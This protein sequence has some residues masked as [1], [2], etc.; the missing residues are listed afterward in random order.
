MLIKV[1]ESYYSQELLVNFEINITFLENSLITY[2][3]GDENVHFSV[4]L[5]HKF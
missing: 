3:K 2:I 5:G 1:W 4:F